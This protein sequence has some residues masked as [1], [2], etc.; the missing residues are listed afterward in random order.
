[1]KLILI[2]ITAVLL[3][4]CARNEITVANSGTKVWR[5]IRVSGGGNYFFIDK[6]EAGEFKTF[7]FVSKQEGSGLFEADLNGR[8]LRHPFEYFASNLSNRIA[9]ILEDSTDGPEVVDLDATVQS[10]DDLIAERRKGEHR[11]VMKNLRVLGEASNAD[12]I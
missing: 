2:T 11:A 7:R 10:I 9:V 6:L 8:K 1:M 4:G 5:E 3:A 12:G